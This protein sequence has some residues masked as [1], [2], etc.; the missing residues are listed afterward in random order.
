MK[1]NRFFILGLI[2]LLVVGV[3][4]IISYQV[5]AQTPDDEDDHWQNQANPPISVDDDD[6]PIQGKPSITPEEAN[7]AVLSEYPGAKIL[8]TELEME[9]GVLVFSVELDNGLEV[10]VDAGSGKILSAEPDD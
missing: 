6:A 3:M 10:A 1:V 2:V 5:L 9:R 7:A 4:G 8:E